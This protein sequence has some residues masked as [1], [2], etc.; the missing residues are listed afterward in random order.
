MTIEI[1]QLRETEFEAARAFQCEY[2]DHETEA[3]FAERVRAY[4]DLYAAAF[5]DGEL[6][7]V[8]YGQ[9]RTG[10]EATLQGIA[11]SLDPSKNAARRGIGSSLVRAFEKASAARGYSK[12]SL[13]SADDIKVEH[14]YLKNGFRPIELAAFGPNHEQYE[15]TPVGDYE[16]GK[17]L[18]EKLRLTYDAANIIFIFE[19]EVSN[20]PK[21]IDWKNKFHL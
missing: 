16:A 7:G 10:A 12:I 8:C 4:P 2:L 5:R 19:K 14:F 15:R 11:V 3:Q 21:Y 17:M 13:G 18:R 6:L 20:E 9:P 1:R